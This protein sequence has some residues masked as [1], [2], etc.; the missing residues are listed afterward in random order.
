MNPFLNPASERLSEWRNF[1]AS[2]K[3][4]T[5]LDQL[6]KVANWCSQ[7]PLCNYSM[8]WDNPKSWPTP[9]QLIHEGIF[10]PT[11]VAYLMEQTLL[12]AGWSSERL[13]LIYVK[14]SE[15]Q[16]EKMLLLVDD[17]WVLNYAHGEVFNFDNIRSG[18]ALLATYQAM[19]EGH[20]SV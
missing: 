18:S 6:L 17:E 13:R 9:W 5:D 16:V 12:M 7:A 15:E 11:A 8:D 14:N 19:D 20:K 2:I 3:D 4:M 1:R 10:C